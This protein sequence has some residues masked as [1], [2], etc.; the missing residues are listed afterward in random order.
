MNVS[1]QKLVVYLRVST[2]RQG[3]SGLGLEGQQ[4]AIDAFVKQ[5]GGTVLARY[6]EVESAKSDNNRPQLQ[7]ALSHCRLANAVLI[8]AKIDRLARNT[9]FLSQLQESKIEFLCCDNPHATRM[10]LTIL[11]AVAENELTLISN[12]TKAALKAYR[13]RGGK[14]GSQRENGKKLTLEASKRGAQ[15]AGV[16]ARELADSAYLHLKPQLLDWKNAGLS[17]RAI[18]TRLNEMG[19]CTRRGK[20]WSAQQVQNVLDRLMPSQA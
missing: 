15:R 12:R 5:N 9:F 14:L 10:V 7:A 11:M 6:V 8:V 1:N 13:D 2:V 19:H 3:E 17:L 4:A 18:A 16:V 20:S